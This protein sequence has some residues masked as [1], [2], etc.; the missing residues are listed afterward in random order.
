MGATVSVPPVHDL[1]NS[2]ESMK[3]VP[4]W[5]NISMRSSTSNPDLHDFDAIN[6]D[7]VVSMVRPVYYMKEEVTQDELNQATQ[8][9]KSI[10][11]N[12]SDFYLKFR[13]EN[14]EK[15]LPTQE[16]CANYFAD[17][18]YERLFN[19]HA[20]SIDLF[21]GTKMKM[22]VYFMGSI[23]IILESLLEEP[24]K[25]HKMLSNLAKVHNR[26]GVKAMEC[27]NFL[28]IFCLSSYLIFLFVSL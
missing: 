9:W 16:L 7:F 28:Y 25:F 24:D 27:K 5:F 3:R 22:R 8:V 17:L 11:N 21:S 15:N 14:K 1:P 6:E 2:P 19:V 20:R 18:F 4:S 10:L 13:Q 12:R 23:T 26:I